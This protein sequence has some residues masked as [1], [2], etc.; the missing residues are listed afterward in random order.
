MRND[1]III[2]YRGDVQLFHIKVIKK[3]LEIMG[4]NNYVGEFKELEDG[5]GNYLAVNLLGNI[6]KCGAIKP[7]FPLKTGRYEVF[8]KQF[9]P[10]QGFGILIVSTP[11][12]IMTNNDAKE[13]GIGGKL[14]AYCY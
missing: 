5:K 9:L 4:R 3:V 10:A 11:Q 12:G 6:N 13:K 8:E 1:I 14:L 7:R 2:R